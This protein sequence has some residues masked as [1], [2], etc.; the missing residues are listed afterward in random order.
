LGAVSG[1]DVVRKVWG[2]KVRGR[3]DDDAWCLYLYTWAHVEILGEHDCDDHNCDSQ[4]GPLPNIL[5]DLISLAH[6][7]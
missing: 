6:S 7:I 3:R 4:L 5:C 1:C 2:M